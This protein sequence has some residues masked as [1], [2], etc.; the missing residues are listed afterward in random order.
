ME[1]LTFAQQSSYTS[2]GTFVSKLQYKLEA[3]SFETFKTNL[4]VALRQMV[5]TIKGFKTVDVEEALKKFVELDFAKCASRNIWVL[6][7]ALLIMARGGK[8]KDP[9]ELVPELSGKAGGKEG[10]LQRQT[11]LI[12][13]IRFLSEK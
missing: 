8:G 6:A 11:D 10:T 1:G 4:E 9:L 7:H 5:N 12:R 2:G 13:Y 3:E